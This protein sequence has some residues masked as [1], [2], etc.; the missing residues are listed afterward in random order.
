MNAS[1]AKRREWER[2]RSMQVHIL[3]LSWS[4]DMEW[5]RFALRS[6]RRFARG[7]SGVTVVYPT[8]DDAVMRPLCESLGARPFPREEPP[9]PLGHLGQNLAKARADQFVPDGTT[10][11]LHFDSDCILTADAT[12]EHYM[13]GGRPVLVHRRWEDAGPAD[14]WREPTRRALGWDPVFETMAC[15]PLF[16]D[17]RVYPMMRAHVEHVHSTAF[18]QYVMGCRPT[19]PYGFCEFN[20]L[21]NFALSRAPE[22]CAPVLVGQRPWTGLADNI[23][24]LWSHDDLQDDMRAWLEETIE[25]G[26]EKRP[27]PPHGEMTERRRKLLGL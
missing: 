25:G 5:L 23:R 19:W 6:I 26:G 9:P 20:A 16:F 18:D 4:P 8:Q 24:Q 11:V 1:A 2:Q 7:F 27:P 22:M 3:I 13:R 14:C 12:P 10:H 21:G 17:V 15:T